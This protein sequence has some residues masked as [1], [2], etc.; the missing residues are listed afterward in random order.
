MHIQTPWHTDSLADA[1]AFSRWLRKHHVALFGLLNNP[2]MLL[3]YDLAKKMWYEGQRQLFAYLEAQT[4]DLSHKRS[5]EL[6][7]KD[8]NDPLNKTLERVAQARLH[9]IF[10]E[11]KYQRVDPDNLRIPLYAD[12]LADLLNFDEVDIEIA[13]VEQKETLNREKG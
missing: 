7:N 3:T 10:R 13:G 2:E 1:L 6:Y 5:Q 11:M 12:Y 9:T 8:K 4:A